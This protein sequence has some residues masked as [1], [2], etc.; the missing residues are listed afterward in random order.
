MIYDSIVIGSSF[1]ALGCIVG[2]LRSNKK[3]LCL[4][5][6]ENTLI[7]ND[8]KKKFEYN[9]SKQNIPIKKFNFKNKSNAVFDPIDVLES[10]SFGGLSNVW[11]TSSLRYSKS[12]FSDWPV[13]YETL[14]EY[15]T[16]C[17]KI[18]NVSH[19][20]DDLSKEHEISSKYFNNNKINLYSEFIRNFLKNKKKEKNLIIG[21]SRIALGT[22]FDNCGCSSY[23]CESCTFSTKKYLNNLIKNGLIDYKKNLIVK[24]YIQKEDKIQLEFENSKINNIFAK[25]LYL[26]AGS[27]KTPRIVLN[28]N[29][30]NYDLELKESQVFF[31]PGFFF[32]KHFINKKKYH[33]LCQSQFFFKKNEFSDI[34]KVS[35][36]IKYD[37]NLTTSL[38][39]QQFGFIHHLIPKFIINRIFL[40]SGFIHSNYSS[41]TATINYKNSNYNIYKNIQNL[42]KIKLTIKNQLKSLQFKFMFFLLSPFL[43]I[44]NFGISYHI[45]ATIPM[46][47]KNHIDLSKSN[48]IHTSSKGELSCSKNV[49][50][51]DAS[52]FPSIS[53]GSISLTIMANA[54]RIS[55]ES[56]ND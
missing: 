39:K 52:C 29:N 12:D 10:Y 41:Y 40:I 16:E 51:I 46:K 24:K 6:S 55:I 35:Y 14:E 9:Y 18:M 22:N 25:K 28:S 4:D 38:L 5:G 54:L 27:V 11:G 23:G 8:S 56:L 34:G 36:Q 2:L 1:S 21:Y 32:G 47:E 44:G 49:F 19:F 17:E 30:I 48:K 7:E 15:Y 26:G 53:A 45:G 31:V 33:S 20:D 50:I 3:V 42:K 37:I 13:S 43:K